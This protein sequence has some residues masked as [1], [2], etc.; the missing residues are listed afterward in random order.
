MEEEIWSGF[1]DDQ[2][3][4]PINHEAEYIDEARYTTVT[5]EAVDVS[6]EGLHKVEEE[7]KSEQN[8]N[9]HR[10]NS[11]GAAKANSESISKKVW[12]KKTRKKKFRYESKAERKVTMVKQKAGNHIK[13]DARKSRH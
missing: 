8:G 11:P 5:V 13:A 1:Q 4:E 12:P 9:E 7:D 6:K 3:V 2:T 10:K